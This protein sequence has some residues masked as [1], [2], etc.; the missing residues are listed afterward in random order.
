MLIAEALSRQAAAVAN[1]GG[2]HAKRT[3]F[4]LGLLDGRCRHI[5]NYGP[6][7]AC[8]RLHGRRNCFGWFVRNPG[9]AQAVGR[10]R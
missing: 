7:S 4:R 8:W 9:A 1:V 2:V 6:I 3:N 10:N 5:A